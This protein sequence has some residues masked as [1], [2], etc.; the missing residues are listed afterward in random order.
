MH[1]R[2]HHAFEAGRRL[3]DR[4]HIDQLDL[5]K[6]QALAGGDGAVTTESLFGK[7]KAKPKDPQA[8]AFADAIERAKEKARAKRNPG[9]SFKD[10]K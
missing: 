4:S 9:K 5:A 8:R 2:P 3:G 6:K 7:S 10:R 1:P